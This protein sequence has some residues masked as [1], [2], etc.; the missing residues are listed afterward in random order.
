MSIS[1]K[2]GVSSQTTINA[3]FKKSMR[4][5]ACQ[6]FAL[7]FYYNVVQFNVAKGEEFNRTLEL[8]ANHGPNLSHQHTMKLG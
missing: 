3:I 4:E 1:K 6:E 5:Q 2:R 7:F 8:V